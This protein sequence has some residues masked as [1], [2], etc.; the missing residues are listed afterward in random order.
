MRE[1]YFAQKAFI[2]NEGKLLVVRKS[3]DDPHNP[4]R[5]EVPGGRMNFGEDVDEHLLREVKEEVGVT[6]IPG[7]PFYVWQWQ[8]Q[9]NKDTQVTD[10]QIVA[11]ARICKPSTLDIDTTGRV[12]DDF[13]GEVEWVDFE[14]LP[15]LDLIPNMK[16]VVE[17]FLLLPELDEGRN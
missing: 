12:E 9:R 7:R 8:L 16:P 17:Q 10:I 14:E 11:V 3:M 13:L 6:V 5:W 1:F 15:S 2:V 4:G